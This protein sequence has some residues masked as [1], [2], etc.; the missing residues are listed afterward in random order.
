MRGQTCIEGLSI[1][2][3]NQKGEFDMILCRYT[4]TTRHI[5]IARIENIGG[6]FLERVIIP[7]GSLIFEAPV[8][9][10]LEIYSSEAVTSTL[11]DRIWCEQLQVRESSPMREESDQR[12]NAS[13][14]TPQTFVT[15]ITLLRRQYSA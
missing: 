1:E 2:C 8:A 5:Q 15:D 14:M 7:E 11:S 6:W 13:A 9:A 4:N 10:Q 12:Q 3:P